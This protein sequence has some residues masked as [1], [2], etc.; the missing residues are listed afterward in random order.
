M[1][2]PKQDP[3]HDIS[4]PISHDVLQDTYLQPAESTR[5]DV[6]GRIARALAEAE[7][8]G[9]RAEWAAR[10]LKAQRDGFVPAGRIAAYAGTTVRGTMASCF[11]QPLADSIRHPVGDLPSIYAALGEAAET[12]RLGGGVG[13][14]FSPIRP[15]GA[16]V[17][18]TDTLAA[19]PL[20]FMRLFDASCELLGA[21]AARR[22]AQMA[23]M[24]C[25]HPD[26]EAFTQAK[27]G[28]SLATFNLSV[29]VSDAFMHALE[30]GAEV[31]L[32][33][34]AEP[35]AAQVAAGA[36]RRADGRWVYRRVPARAL[37]EDFVRHGHERGEPG[38]LFIDRINRD[39]NL[40][41]CEHIAA[42]NPCG[43]EPLPPY[44]GCC[45]GSVDLT[46][47]V[48]SP[49]EPTARL[50]TERLAEIVPVAVRML[51]DVLELT[52][53][54]LPAQR[55]QALAKR[56]IGLGFTGLGDALVMLGLHYGSAAART[57]ATEVARLMRD[58]AYRA[59]VALARERGPFPLFDAD[60]VLREGSFASR[61]PEALRRDI[62][63]H[64][65]RNSHLL[66]IAPAG[67]VTLA[68]ADNASSGIEPAFAWSYLRHRRRRL[69]P[70]V[71][72]YE[73]EDHA[74]R[75]HQ[76]LKGA[77]AAPTAAFV[78]A[79]EL[80]PQDHL[81][82]LAAVAPYIDAGISKTVNAPP[83]CP[84][85]EFEALYR[86]AW[87]SGLKG[88]TAFRPS[89]VLGSVLQLPAAVAT[90]CHA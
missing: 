41:Y 5:D 69:A 38:V 87:R 74:W 17:A 2:D 13:I 21:G 71:I 66:S 34:A 16:R 47:L 61:L 57:L 3:I 79:M 85:A 83:A 8:P 22:G 43:E 58:C 23:V 1:L 28:G 24:R 9:Q 59:S 35:G 42:T 90:P 52:T 39:N 68:F 55:R 7:P 12:L 60:G 48:E 14:D 51:D 37:W 56:R 18:G 40:A 70:G 50:A 10:F 62:R 27:A 54:P 81:A 19:G 29:A 6:R 80:S 64:G 49:F 11:V 67:S 45:L 33:H 86:Q 75:L 73:V 78:T 36:V 88:L 20:A 15:Q 4:Q 46:R 77:A 72:A 26:I 53:W 31:E 63:E 82:M 76:R 84:Y 65:L 32:V 89:R 44:G 25:D 30:A